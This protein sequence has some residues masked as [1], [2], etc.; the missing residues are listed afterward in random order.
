M[1][2]G[3]D[4]RAYAFLHAG[5]SNPG[6]KTTSYTT[7]RVTPRSVCHAVHECEICFCLFTLSRCGLYC[8][9]YLG[10]VYDSVRVT[11]PA[12]FPLLWRRSSAGARVTVTTV[13][14]PPPQHPGFPSVSPFTGL[15]FPAATTTAGKADARCFTGNEPLPMR[16]SGLGFLSPT[17]SFH[18]CL[19]K[20]RRI[21]QHGPKSHQIMFQQP[22]LWF[23]EWEFPRM[24]CQR[25]CGGVGRSSKQNMPVL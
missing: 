18:T 23:R 5:E 4:T 10:G 17:L 19:V 13:S 12:V 25:V 9:T 24:C 16:T 7:G 15:F 11:T 2:F 20:V 1:G 14:S 21:N 22:G 8:C 6:S 3:S